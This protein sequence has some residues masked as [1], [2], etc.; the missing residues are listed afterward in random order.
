MKLTMKS[1]LSIFFIALLSGFGGAMLYNQLFPNHPIFVETTRDSGNMSLTNFS[2]ASAMGET[3]FV[4]AS[5]AS[6]ESVVYIKTIAASDYQRYS[7]L[8][9]FFEGRGRGSERHVAGSGS[10]VTEAISIEEAS[11]SLGGIL[12]SISLFIFFRK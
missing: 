5:E 1:F 12:S 4:A 10:G 6:T 2:R 11:S 7:F 3:N 9:L 8:D